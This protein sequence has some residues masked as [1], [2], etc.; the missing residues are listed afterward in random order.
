MRLKKSLKVQRNRNHNI[1]A[2]LLAAL[3]VL[4]T[5]CS[6]DNPMAPDEMKTPTGLNPYTVNAKLGRGMNLGNALEAPNEGEWGVTLQSNYFDLIKNAGFNSVRIPIRWSTHA[7][8]GSPFLVSPAFFQRI[9]WAIE[10]S[11]SRGLAVIINMHHYEEIMQDPAAHKGRF[12]AIWTQLADHYKN[13]SGDL[14]FEILNEPNASLT[15][16]LWNQY[17][18][19]AITVVRKS[20]PG[21]ILMVGP[22]NF[23]NVGSLG[24][25]TLPADDKNIIV[26]FHYY[27]PFQ[28]THQGADWVSGSE[29]WL[30]TTWTGTP[31]QKQAVTRDFSTAVNWGAAK[32]R[33]INVGEFGAYSRA[34]M[35][36]RAAWTDF[37]ARTA[38]ANSMSWH[39]WEFISGFGAYNGQLNDWNYSLLYALIP[40]TTPT[41]AL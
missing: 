35:S 41:S 5:G 30:G 23:Y 6:K 11:F 26:S 25:L 31:A 15:A 3:I 14:V 12:L 32:D 17:L 36:S 40:K 22:A 37:V 4:G 18:G 13:Y 1:H 20:N 2:A 33:P 8:T 7:T 24:S 9:D 29:A 16:Q 38:E 21:R 19:E 10:Q 34:A 39:Y 28:F 27:N